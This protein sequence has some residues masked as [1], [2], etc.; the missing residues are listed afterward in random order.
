[1]ARSDTFI[2][3]FDLWTEDQHR[4]ANA[5]RERAQSGELKLFRLAWADIHG[6]SRTKIVTLPAF[7][8]ALENGYNTNVATSTLDPSGARV[9][10]SF[11]QGGGMNLEE[12]TGSP[13]LTI[14]P[15]PATFRVLPWEPQV[16]WILCDEYFTSGR[17]FHFAPRQL[18]R[19]QLERLRDRNWRSVVGLE[20]EWYLL[21]LA[22]GPLR[23]ENV[24]SPGV[25]GRA[26]ATHPVEAGYSFHSETNLDILHPVIASLAEA[27][28]GLGLP[29][30]SI[31]NEWGPGQLECTFGPDDAL[32]AADN[33]ILFRTATRQICR[34]LG[35]LATFMTRPK[36]QGYCSSGWHLHQSLVEASSGRNLFVPD[37]ESELLSPLGHAYLGGLTHNALSA[38]LFANPTVNGYRRFRLN[39]LAPDRVAWCS[40]HRG[41][42]LRVLG[43]RDNPASRIENRIGEPFANPYLYILSQILGGLDGIDH[44]RDPG[45]SDADP[46]A[47]ARPMLPK[48]LKEAVQLM[49]E[50]SLY[51]ETLGPIF[52]DYYAQLKLT[53]LSRFE[54]FLSTNNIA[55]DSE[56]T[57]EWEQDEYLDFF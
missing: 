52:V 39:S 29:L 50:T 35:F 42:M 9:F 40:D 31:E 49:R 2:R 44:N 7:L 30:R 1:M 34:R 11:T 19:Q 20:V 21:K 3:R 14:V 45:P 16:G 36:L 8:G 32:A 38:T 43:G 24:G 15:D 25:R 46:Y 17:P 57:T 41:A 6:V 37:S 12:M 33:L 10:A 18:L 56:E 5:I 28:E 4:Q 27:L 54:T 51:R 26:P 22:D 48:S 47:A 13:N 23:S 55:L 53:E